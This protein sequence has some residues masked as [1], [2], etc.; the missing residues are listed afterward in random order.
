ACGLLEDEPAVMFMNL[1]A[2]DS[3]TGQCSTLGDTCNIVGTI[4]NHEFDRGSTE[5]LRKVEGGNSDQGPYLVD[6]YPGA[7]FPYVCANAIDNETG[8]TLLPPY[9]IKS[10]AGVSVAFIGAV[11]SNVPSVEKPDMITNMTFQDEADSI[12][13]LIPEIQSQGVHAIVV[14]IHE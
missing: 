11:T 13:A 8:Q 1:L 4:G 3:C 5:L 14:V 6:P 12:N 10:V 9:V 7:S 2:N